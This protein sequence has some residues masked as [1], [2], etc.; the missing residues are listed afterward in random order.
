MNAGPMQPTLHLSSP[1]AT[2]APPSG[3]E[4]VIPFPHV[5]GTARRA[6]H[7]TSVGTTARAAKRAIDLVVA[8][9]ALIL[10]APVLLLA[11]IAIVIDSPGPVLFSQVRVGRGGRRFHILKL[12]TMRHGCDDRA[13]ADYVRRLAAGR[14]ETHDGLF[15]LTDDPRITRVGRLLRASSIDELPQ[16]VNVLRGDMSLVG[17]RPMIEREV[18]LLG[19]AGTARQA[20]RPGITGPWQVCGRSTLDFRQMIGLDL[21]YARGWSVWGDLRILARTPSAVLSRKGAA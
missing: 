11:A 3:G 18:A 20:V 10:A 1:S 9:L 4:T 8:A 13:H 6:P 15:K 16:L 19:R 2:T 7:G 12:R 5:V 17:P 21:A 14:A